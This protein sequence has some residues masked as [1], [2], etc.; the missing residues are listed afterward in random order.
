[1]RLS[2]PERPGKIEA[3]EKYNG[4][5]VSPPGSGLV[6]RP[7]SFYLINQYG[8]IKALQT[9]TYSGGHNPPYILDLT[10]NDPLPTAPPPPTPIP[11]PTPT[12]APTATP[13]PTA[14]PT[15]TLTPTPR[16]TP[17]LP[18]TGDR[19]VTQ[20][21]K[22]MLGLGAVVVLGSLVLLLVVRRRG[23]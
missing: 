20:I 1:M 11:T 13:R 10:F 3:S 18:V 22:L 15:P 8:R 14:T 17:S 16:P 7:I 5:V 23:M 4:L 21:P 6:G 12:P 19:S 9:V 2:V